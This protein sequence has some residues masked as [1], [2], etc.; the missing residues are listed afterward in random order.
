MVVQKISEAG[1]DEAAADRLNGEAAGGR[2]SDY[3]LMMADRRVEEA[4]RRVAEQI[5]VVAEKEAAG[6]TSER[7]T[8]LLQKLQQELMLLTEQRE[9][10]RLGA[11][12]DSPAQAEERE[13][14]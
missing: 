6:E 8:A 1:R 3:S 11:E 4:S 12:A 2:S 7:A 13:T 5:R 14:G 10:A 9:A